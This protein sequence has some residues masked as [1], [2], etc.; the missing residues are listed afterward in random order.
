MSKIQVYYER[1]YSDD[2]GKHI[3]SVFDKYNP[4]YISYKRLWKDIID[5]FFVCKNSD[6]L[7]T[8]TEGNIR[9]IV[10]TEESGENYKFEQY[11]LSDLDGK[12][13]K[14]PKGVKYAIQNIDESKSAL[15]I[16]AYS[17]DLDFEYFNK[18]IFNW[19]KKNG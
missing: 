15:L 10:V 13:I 18:K 12:V 1:V 8:V 14:I 16:G 2:S 6:L 4:N 19:R 17:P 3:Q 9:I 11:F 5:G 7:I